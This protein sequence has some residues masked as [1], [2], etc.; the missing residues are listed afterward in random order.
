MPRLTEYVQMR[1]HTGAVLPSFTLTDL[2]GGGF[3]RRGRAGRPA[4][5]RLDLLAADL[6]C[7]CNDLFS[8]G[9]ERGHGGHN[10]VAVIVAEHRLR[11]GRGA[12]RGR[13]AGSTPGWPRTADRGRGAARRRPAAGADGAVPGGTGCAATY[14]WSMSAESIRVTAGATRRR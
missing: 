9:K 10:L 6:V 8:Y 14:D 13:R 12:G 5:A 3:P 7:W 11:G 4:V 1:R 2:V